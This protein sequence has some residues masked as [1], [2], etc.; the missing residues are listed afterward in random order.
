MI[1][2][3]KDISFDLGYVQN[4]EINPFGTPIGHHVTIF[5]KDGEA[6]GGG[7]SERKEDALR[8]ATAEIIER[9]LFKKISSSSKSLEFFLQS[10]PTTCG[11]A[12]GF[13]RK[14]TLGR[15]ELESYE[16]W[17]WSKWI[18]EKFYISSA[19]IQ[20]ENLPPLTQFFRREF[21]EVH[22]YKLK[23]YKGSTPIYLG[24]SLGFK[25]GGVFPGSRAA[26]SENEIWPHA[27]L[28]SWRHYISFVHMKKFSKEPTSIVDKRIALF[29]GD[30]RH[31][32]R[33]IPLAGEEIWPSPKVAFQRMMQVPGKEIYL[34]RTLCEDFIGWHEGPASRFV[35]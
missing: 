22:F 6:L 2:A 14:K 35:Y 15:S 27:L 23:F 31:A 25:N 19:S 21:E 13:D 7:C 30:A 4:V 1:S 11:F 34:A 9:T 26:L 8:V 3:L 28:E 10:F 16:R 20:A 24:I 33:Q 18:D 29:G 5:N 17:A 32:I 12:A